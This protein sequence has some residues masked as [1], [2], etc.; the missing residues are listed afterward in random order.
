VKVTISG[1]S[2]TR[3]N[4][5][6]FKNNL[7]QGIGISEVNFPADSWIKPE[8]ITFYAALTI[9]PQEK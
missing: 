4:L 7:Q 6:I 5:V 2:D 8:N 1:I 9:K 3:D